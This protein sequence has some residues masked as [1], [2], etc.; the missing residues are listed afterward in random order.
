MVDIK[1]VDNG[2]KCSRNGCRA[3][4]IYVIHNDTDCFYPKQ[5]ICK[6]CADMIS[7]IHKKELRANTVRPYKEVDVKAN[8]DEAI[9]GTFETI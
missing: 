8:E 7:G 5:Y 4:G 6:S 3:R 1:K 9:Q 2:V